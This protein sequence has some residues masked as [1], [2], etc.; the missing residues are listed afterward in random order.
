MTATADSAKK[1]LTLGAALKEFGW[2]PA[3]FTAL[4]GAPSMPSILEMA[5]DFRLI[6]AFRWIADG[7]NQLTAV[8]ARLIEPLF[9]PA[10][11]WMN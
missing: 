6:D 9:A 8:V 1:T 7:Y 3:V 5:L 4:V 2:L 10:I 11:A